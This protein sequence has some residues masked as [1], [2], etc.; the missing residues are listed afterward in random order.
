MKKNILT[1]LLVLSVL[2]ISLFVGCTI[3]KE[4][5]YLSQINEALK[6]TK[7]SKGAVFA[8]DVKSNGNAVTQE[9]TSY[10]VNGEEVSFSATTT[11]PNPDLFGDK[12]VT[13][14]AKGT[15]IKADY[16][17]K[18]YYSTTL[19]EN[20]I[21]GKINHVTIGEAQTV[22]TFSVKNASLFLNVESSEVSDLRAS[23]KV[24][25]DRL[26]EIELNYSYKGYTVKSKY[27]I[28]Y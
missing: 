23:I 1:I 14:T 18:L 25:G 21:D 8:L 2:A 6:T 22:Y 13:D 15:I 10:S 7:T 9:N 17:S 4:D 5:N 19:T 27:T 12:L 20:D 3:E 16:L 11:K 26:V 28:N 24:S